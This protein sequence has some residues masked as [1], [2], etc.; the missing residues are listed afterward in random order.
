MA[1]FNN[2]TL[3]GNLTRDVELRHVGANN[4]AVA[5]VSI[6]VNERVKKGD[7]WL[8][9]VNFFDCVLW[10]RKAEVAAE[11]LGKGSPILVSGRLKQETWEKDGQKRSKVKIIVNELQM[12]GKKGERN[13]HNQEQP[14]SQQAADMNQEVPF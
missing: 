5:D 3:V 12:L 9:E 4:T 1:S 7:D 6:A 10:S 2:V 8:D 14:K 13:E 11:Y